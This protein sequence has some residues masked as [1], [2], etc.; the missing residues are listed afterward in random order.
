MLISCDS[1]VVEPGDLWLER[2]PAKYRDRAP[3]AVQDP[4][5]HHWYF[6]GPD[7]PRGVDLTLS[8][9][10]G[11]TAREV[12][13]ILAEDP[14]AWVGARGGH[15]P[16]ERLRDMWADD[17]IADVLYPTAGLSLLSYD[18]A[19][20]QFACI[21]AYNNWLAEFCAT[22]KERL[23]GLAMVPTWDI[24]RAVAEVERCSDLGLRGGLM[25]ASPPDQREYSYFTDHYER[26]WAVAAERNFPLSMHILAGHG[27]KGMANYGKTVEDTFYFGVVVRDEIQRTLSELIIAGVFERHPNL[28]IVAAEAG[29][30]YVARLE[31]RLD[32]TMKMWWHALDHELKLMPSEY[33]RRNVYCTYISD[34]IGLNNLR[35][36]DAAHFMWS[37]DY[38]HGAATWPNSA[39]TVKAEFDE[40]GVPEDQ[41]VRLTLTNVAELYGIDIETVREPSPKL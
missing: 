9:N 32:S 24:A 30:D 21:Q 15:D 20:F 4:K 8:R 26:L 31:K 3:R 34:P 12:D 14:D 25:W 28:H 18:D 29:I 10:A 23:I 1:H 37:S 19:E 16:V 5:N 2:L 36:T 11:M 17:T 35:F 6:T 22:D 40:F 27:S 39:A 41:R 13:D 38:P 33:F 7:L